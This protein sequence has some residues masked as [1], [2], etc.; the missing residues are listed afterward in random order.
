MLPPYRGVRHDIDLEP[1][2]KNY[3]TRQ[4]PLPK[5]QVDTIDVFFSET[6]SRPRPRVE[7]ATLVADVLCAQIQWEMAHISFFYKLNAVTI[8][9]STPIPGK[10]VLQN[11]MTGCNITSA[12]GS[13][14]A[15]I[16][17]L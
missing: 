17:Y 2:T 5:E 8:P 9:A 14:M 15:I 16:N 12:L 11:N 3:T 13:S 7:I 1:G 4:W 10:D 6:R